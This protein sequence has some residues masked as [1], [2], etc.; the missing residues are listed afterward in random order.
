MKGI[1]IIIPG[2]DFSNSPL[3]TVTFSKSV[4]EQAADIVTA[5]ATV[6]GDSTHNEE[7]TDMVI[8]LMNLGVWD[9]L[10][11]Y[12]MLGSTL[13]NKLVNLNPDGFTGNNLVVGAN[14]SNDTDCI[15]FSNVVDIGGYSGSSKSSTSF[16][17]GFFCFIDF[18]FIRNAINTSTIFDYKRTGAPTALG[19]SVNTVV[20]SGI[21]ARV[22][23]KA[24]GAA[25]VG[26]AVLW[27]STTG[28]SIRTK[29]LFGLYGNDLKCIDESGSYE[30]TLTEDATEYNIID[31]IGG[32][33]TTGD[34][35]TAVAADST[36]FNG[37]IHMFA[38]GNV[39]SSKLSLVRNAL[40]IF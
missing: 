17:N 2:A 32:V 18:N 6:I 31:M 30:F 24:A 3:G 40:S 29:S 14:A 38:R 39:P 10:D 28:T 19:L 25:A 9:N 26:N 23:F 13:N 34:G 4:E 12:P 36:L 11:I 16:A 15:S 22:N 27:D 37:K 35:G 33:P 20:S 1:S 21:K 7:L 8:N 5:Y